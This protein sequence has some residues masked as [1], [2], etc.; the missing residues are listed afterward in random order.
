MKNLE[1]CEFCIHC[2]D[3]VKPGVGD[4]YDIK[5]NKIAI[6]SIRGLHPSLVLCDSKYG[7]EILRNCKWCP[8]FKE[9]EFNKNINWEGIFN[10]VK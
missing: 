1:N 2:K 5:E 8:A 10:E 7:K 4:T 6:L 9:Q 3:Y